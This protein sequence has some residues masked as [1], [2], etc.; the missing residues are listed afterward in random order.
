[1]ENPLPSFYGDLVQALCGVPHL[2]LTFQA[3][4]IT[5]QSIRLLCHD[6]CNLATSG[7]SG[8]SLDLDGTT[9]AAV[10]LRLVQGG[11]ILQ[12]LRLGV[13]VREHCSPGEMLR[14]LRYSSL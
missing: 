13:S 10:P 9:E 11:C 6:T 12:H 14:C 4:G 2:L 1:M 7:I 5:L 8:L 3:A